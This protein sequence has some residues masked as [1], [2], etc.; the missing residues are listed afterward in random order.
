MR[1][2]LIT[3]CSAVALM[4]APAFAQSTAQSTPQTP[5]M[6]VQAP[7]PIS[8]TPACAPSDPD[9]LRGDQGAADTDAETPGSTGTQSDTATTG[10]TG[11]TGTTGGTTSDTGSTAQ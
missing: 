11:S 10:G 9:C 1:I 2:S 8:A 3:M 6:G 4:A 7:P 5:T